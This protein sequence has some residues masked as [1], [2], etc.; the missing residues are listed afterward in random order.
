ME[1]K[2]KEELILYP[3]P[4]DGEITLVNYQGGV[5]TL[6]LVDALGKLVF[7]QVVN[8][9]SAGVIINFEHLPKGMYYLKST[10]EGMTFEIN[11]K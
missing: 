3:N 6:K 7:F 4:T 1:E 9:S 10:T 5:E 11:K 2:E 8:V